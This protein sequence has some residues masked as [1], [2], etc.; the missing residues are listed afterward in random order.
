MKFGIF[1]NADWGLGGLVRFVGW[2]DSWIRGFVG[3]VD[4]WDSWIGDGGLGCMEENKKSG[5]GDVRAKAL[6]WDDEWDKA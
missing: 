1:Q 4:W 2:W 6:A 3:F 5:G